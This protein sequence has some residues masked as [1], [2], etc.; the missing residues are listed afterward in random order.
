VAAARAGLQDPA[1]G[2]VRLTGTTVGVL[3]KRPSARR[4][5]FLRAPVFGPA[6]RCAEA[7]PDGYPNRLANVRVSGAGAVPDRGGLNVDPSEVRIP[8]GQRG[9]RRAARRACS[10]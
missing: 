1:V 3:P 6:G 8:A 7:A 9:A 5:P 4:P 2:L 10:G